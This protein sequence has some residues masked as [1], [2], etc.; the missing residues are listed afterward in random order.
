MSR[1]DLTDAKWFTS[2][3]SEAN[4]Q[5]VEVAHVGDDMVALRDTKD[6]GAGPV[7]IFTGD[8]W[9]AFIDAAGGLFD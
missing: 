7:M 8:Q 2:S 5:C 9:Q 3:R 1:V 4:G 6:R